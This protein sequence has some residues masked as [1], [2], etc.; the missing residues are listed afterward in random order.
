V[1]LS[2]SE[3]CPIFAARHEVD[4]HYFL[5]TVVS[6]RHVIANPSPG[7]LKGLLNETTWRIY[8]D[9][10]SQAFKTVINSNQS[11]V[12]HDACSGCDPDRL[13]RFYALPT[14]L[15]VENATTDGSWIQTIATKLRPRLAKAFVGAPPLVEIA[16]AGGIGE[17]PKELNRL[18]KRYVDARPGSSV[19]LRVLVVS[20][21]DAKIPGQPSAEAREVVRA[22]AELGASSHVLA[23]RT[24]ENYF[25]DE[26]LR[27]YARQRADR[28]EVVE[29]ITGL[30][31]AAR[32]H[33]P[34]KKGLR[35]SEVNSV[36]PQYD[37][38]IDLERGLGDFTDDLLSNFQYSITA[39]DLKGRDGRGELEELLDKLERNL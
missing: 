3:E 14:L 22:A 29:L 24:I 21:S 30:S 13:A 37:A 1:I 38:G 4:L 20:D 27:T 33:Y 26:S 36:T 25:P 6:Q 18:G 7:K 12:A 10:I 23:K 32:D 15:I 17:I 9:F 16:Q 31:G 2:L 11:W 19:P 39:P 28:R 8:G 5:H 34:M 35:A